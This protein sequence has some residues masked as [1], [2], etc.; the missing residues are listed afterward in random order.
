MPISIQ[1]L[2]E[3]DR[4]LAERRKREMT[5]NETTTAL[6]VIKP[7]AS[8]EVMPLY[9]EALKLLDYAEQ[10]VITTAEDI[11]P[12][13]DDLSIIS[14]LKKALKEK[15]K[16]YIQPLQSQVKTI[17]DAFKVLMEPIEQADQLT[18][19]RILAFQK[20]EDAKRAEEIRIND[21]RSE[22]AQRDAA[23]HG[24]EISESVNL[25]E[26]SP[27]APKRVS[28]E[29]GTVGQR[30]N[31]KWEVIDFSI[32]PDEYKVIDGA[33]LTAIAKKHHDLKQ[34]PGVRFYNEPIIA[35]NA[36]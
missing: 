17:N 5:E 14:K 18:R 34:I 15:R 6:L 12:A 31:W 36:R 11:K 30:E 28:T 10:R 35:V 33:I 13:T 7:E 1:L 26:V 21:L 25:V 19:S 32:V 2:R 8:T 3:N 27:E 9:N 20:A 29:M 23:L 4:Y 24:G 16:E 22:A